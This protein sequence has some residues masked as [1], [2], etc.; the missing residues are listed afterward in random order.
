MKA[1]LPIAAI[2]AAGFV[3]AVLP[4]G[5]FGAYDVAIRAGICGL[6]AGMTALLLIAWAKRSERRERR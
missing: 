3:N 5:D 6:V 2:A 1:L 4:R